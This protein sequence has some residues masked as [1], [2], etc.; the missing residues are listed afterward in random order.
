MKQVFLLMMAV[1]LSLP[2]M[3]QNKG[4][5]KNKPATAN[6]EKAYKKVYEETAD[7]MAQIDQAIELAQATNRKVICQV[8]GNWCPW[9][10]KFAQFITEDPE[11]ATL[12]EKHYVYVHLNTSKENKNKEALARL[13][14]P[15]RFGYPA[16]VIL[17]RDGMVMQIQNSA[18]LE[19]GKS[20]DRK[21]VL[22]FFQN[23]TDEAIE[24]IK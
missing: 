13:G 8:G 14:N 4:G 1:T 21:K 22:E 10:L 18:Y 15:G 17:N 24:L 5:D 7:G 11:I 16:L 3:A 12:I 23:W 20:Y 6:T 19:S 2:M 9:C